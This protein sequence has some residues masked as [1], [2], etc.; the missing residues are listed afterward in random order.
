MK[1]KLSSL[2]LKWILYDAGNSAFVLL[3]AS[4]LPI[5]FNYLASEG[6]LSETEYLT[7]WSYAASIATV[8][9]AFMGP[10]MGTL[11]DFPRRKKRIFLANALIG[12]LLLFCFWIPKA[13]SAFLILFVL[14]KVLYSISLVIYD[15]MLVDIC[16]EDKM[17]MVSSKGYAWGYLGSCVPFII[18]LGLM[19]GYENLGISFT[20]AIACV[21]GLNAAWWAGLTLPLAFGYKQRHSIPVQGSAIPQTFS[22]LFKLMKTIGK[23]KKILLF[24]LGFFF[25]IDGVYTIID[26]AT[27]YGTSL[28]LDQTGL[29][30]A[31]LLTQVIAF[32]AAILFG[33]LAKNYSAARL[34]KVGIFAYF[35]ISVFALFMYSIWQFW[36]LAAAV[37][38]FQ[39][40][41]QALSRSYYARIIPKDQAGEYFGLYDIAGKGASFLGTT[42]VGFLTQLTGQQNIA[43]GALAILFVIGY[44]IFSKA[45]KLEDPI[46]ANE[47]L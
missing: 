17:D 37:G 1:N 15:S 5:Y 19:L 41:L 32:P 28:G 25:Y 45:A 38:I 39:G 4:I 34:I 36:I 11:A 2:E 3:T 13:W 46:Y 22:R 7:W 14:C 27:A 21:F 44:F 35:C 8:I 40:G 26:M 18:S 24:M 47:T 29:L 43:V 9:V 42:V 10:I 30:L 23:Q 33:Y 20:A 16:D 31:L 12:A 6:G